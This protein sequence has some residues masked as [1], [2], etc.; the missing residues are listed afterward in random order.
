MTT[1]TIISAIQIVQ[2]FSLLSFDAHYVKKMRWIFSISFNSFKEKRL[3][4][5]VK[6]NEEN[7]EKS[8]SISE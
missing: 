8:N 7:C 5:A 2:F 3:T 1:K 6:W 4:L